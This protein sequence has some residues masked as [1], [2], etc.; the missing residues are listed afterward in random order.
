MLADLMMPDLVAKGVEKAASRR[1]LTSQNLT[2]PLL[3]ER[4]LSISRLEKGVEQIAG[5]LGEQRKE[6]I[7]LLNQAREG[8]EFKSRMEGVEAR[9]NQT[10]G[11]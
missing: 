9:I 10:C 2:V 11:N 4:S 8:A 6:V 3:H 5:E 7:P 1:R